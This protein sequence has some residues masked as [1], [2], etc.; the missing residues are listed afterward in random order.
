[1][2]KR[3][4]LQQICDH[5]G[6]VESAALPRKFYQ[7]CFQRIGEIDL[8]GKGISSEVPFYLCKNAPAHSGKCFLAVGQLYAL[9]FITEY[10]LKNSH[11]PD[12]SICRNCTGVS[13]RS[14]SGTGCGIMILENIGEY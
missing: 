2:K 8:L 12:C 5:T 14:H 1:M 11:I 7:L 4:L 10:L 6:F 13:A 3:G 9:F